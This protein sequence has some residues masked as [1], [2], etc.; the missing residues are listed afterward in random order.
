MALIV[1]GNH[2]RPVEQGTRITRS[3]EAG[4]VYTFHKDMDRGV[5]IRSEKA[6]PYRIP[7]R[8]FGN[9]EQIRD[10]LI[11]KTA[12]HLDRNFTTLLSGTKGTGKTIVSKL[13]FNALYDKYPV[14]RINTALG[15]YIDEILQFLEGNTQRFFLEV[16]E[17][18]K[19]F[20][21]SEWQERLLTFLDGTY[22]GRMIAV[23]TCNDVHRLDK[24]FND[25]PGRIRY[26]II[27]TGLTE[28]IVREVLSYNLLNL[29]D[30][31]DRE[32]ERD[33]SGKIIRWDDKQAHRLEQA[34]SKL[35][36]I[37]EVTYDIVTS[38]AEEMNIKNTDVVTAME[39]MNIHKVREAGFSTVSSN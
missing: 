19:I 31:S 11:L 32:D 18:E 38:V 5:H 1:N 22:D 8:L 3:L 7:S 27:H 6:T 20:H 39:P 13:V 23:L 37:P 30:G 21:K 28:E 16:D 35:I 9:A 2:Y 4:K 33:E 24:N 10:D 36:N 26:N 34:V 17:V 29:K 15:G 25:R 14:V 12:Q